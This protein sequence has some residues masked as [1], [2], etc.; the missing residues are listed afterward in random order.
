MMPMYNHYSIR[1]VALCLIL[2]G[3][4]SACASTGQ[5]NGSAGTPTSAGTV[6]NAASTSIQT[7]D[8][9]RYLPRIG[10][11]S[12][13]L[14]VLKV[15]K[16]ERLKIISVDLV[17]ALVQLPAVNP[18]TVTL[19][20]TQPQTAFGNLVV[21]AL[22]D[23]GYGLQRVSA[24]QGLHYVQYSQRYGETDAG[25]VTD[26]VLRVGDISV[27]REYNENE[28]GVFPS[29]LMRVNGAENPDLIVLNDDIF[30]EQG[31]DGQVFISGVSSGRNVGEV[32]EFS[33]NEYD[34]T[35]LEQRTQRPTQLLSARRAAI[36]RVVTDEELVDYKRLRRTVLVFDDPQTRIMGSGNKQ[37]VRLL[38][39]EFQ[40][41]DV[42]QVAAC[43]DADGQNDES[44][45]RGIRVI[46]EFLSYD[47]P[48][49]NVVKAPCRRTNF[50]HSTD[51]SPVAV[52]VV[53]LRR[54]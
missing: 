46:E 20:V 48:V 1:S 45:Q 47:I 5:N 28:N 4:L 11:S 39:R 3:T 26:Y 37:A 44:V 21:R 25:P 33:V 23:A 16:L 30:K 14:Q 9:T 38:V 51:D 42:I 54:G 27:D 36:A 2:M 17:S 13:S 7:Q 8:V 41:D 19:Q 43:S 6:A 29:S 24:D 10:G 35:P 31:G 15:A 12:A 50:R 49:K 22:E 34:R 32:R 18:N 53:H 52:E 40:N